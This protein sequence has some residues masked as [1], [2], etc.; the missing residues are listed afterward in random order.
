MAYTSLVLDFSIEESADAISFIIKDE[1]TGWD[2]EEATTTSALLTVYKS[3]VAYG[4][5]DLLNTG[6]KWAE[7]LSDDGAEIE[8]S[9][10]IG[11]TDETFE[12]AS[13]SFVLVVTDGTYASGLEPSKQIDK[14]FLA[15]GY[16]KYRKV[17]ALIE[18]DPIDYETVQELFLLGLY[19]ESADQAA[20]DGLD[21][22]FDRLISYINAIFD[23]YE[24]SD[25]L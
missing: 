21:D 5:F 13:Y 6:T 18:Y 23:K 10:L 15:K 8:V 16:F 25:I 20:T 24:I 4:T 12:D 11:V 3:G 19:F 17:G 22:E 2:G 9:D 1:S 7:F 14:A